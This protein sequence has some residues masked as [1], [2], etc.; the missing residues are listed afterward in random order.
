M[1]PCRVHQAN[2]SIAFNQQIIKLSNL[3]IITNRFT[4]CS[5]CNSVVG[6]VYRSGISVILCNSNSD[7]N[8]NIQGLQEDFLK[9]FNYERA[10][11]TF[12]KQ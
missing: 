3:E 12:I 8:L 11:S 6:H 10:V 4:I 9:L 7:Q 2:K 5:R 1:I